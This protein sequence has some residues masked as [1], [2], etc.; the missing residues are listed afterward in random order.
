LPATNG[1]GD[2]GWLRIRVRVTI[3]VALAALIPCSEEDTES[4]KYFIHV[5]GIH[6]AL[7]GASQES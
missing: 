4:V 1:G 6:T 2:D 7:Q 3:V 5:L